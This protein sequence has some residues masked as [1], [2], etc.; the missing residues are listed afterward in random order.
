V[1]ESIRRVVG[2]KEYSITNAEAAEREEKRREEGK[3]GKY[4]GLA[5]SLMMHA[6]KSKT[7]AIQS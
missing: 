7:R 1:K 2:E 4:E 5:A 3:R 6:F